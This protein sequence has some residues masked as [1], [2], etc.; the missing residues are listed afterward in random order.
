[1]KI[2]I[3]A[4]LTIATATIAFTD[5]HVYGGLPSEGE[6]LERNAYVVEYD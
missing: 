3:S 1:M 5:G 2:I 4:L 6:V